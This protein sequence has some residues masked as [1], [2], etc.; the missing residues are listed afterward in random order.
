MSPNLKDKIE[1][2]GKQNRPEMKTLRVNC[3]TMRNR[4]EKVIARVF[5][6]DNK[7]TKKEKE[8]E[9]ISPRLVHRIGEKNTVSEFL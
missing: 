2:K 1:K 6:R 9:R 8:I 5:A 3:E 4:D 7:E